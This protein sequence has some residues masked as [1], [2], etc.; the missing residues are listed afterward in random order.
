MDYL[1]VIRSLGAGDIKNVARDPFLKWMIPAPFAMALAFRFLIPEASTLATPWVEL[2][3][4]Y[5]LLLS[6]VVTFVPLMYGIVVGFMLLDERDENTL[7]ALKVT[8]MSPKKYLLY[9]ITT[10]VVVSIITTLLAYPLVGL[11]DVGL[12]SLIAI[13]A[14][15]SLSAP[16]IALIFAAFARNKV[17]GFA[18]QK[19][20][21]SVL[22]IPLVA[23][24]IPMNWQLLFGTFPTYWPLKA[25]WVA[26]TGEPGVWAYVLAGGLVHLAFIWVLIKRFDTV[27]H[28]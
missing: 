22:M 26:T 21:G 16:F 11:L 23:W 25:F 18:I 2:K 14:L 28:Q 8:P 3:S 19:M 9:R 20:L 15:S 24:F 13:I 17:E 5:P 1:K 12:A 27:M 6:A 7:T 4:Y 10:P